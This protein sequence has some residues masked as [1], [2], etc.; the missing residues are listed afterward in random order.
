MTQAS[1]QHL[2]CTVKAVMA[3]VR[4]IQSQCSAATWRC[5]MVRDD[6]EEG[7]EDEEKRKQK[8]VL[9][10]FQLK[11]CSTQIRKSW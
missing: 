5:G 8:R 6:E 1:R 9:Y 10:C 3:T 7:M 2:Q 4:V 11:K